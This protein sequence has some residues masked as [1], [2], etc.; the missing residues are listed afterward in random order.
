M[1]KCDCIL[2]D[3]GKLEEAQGIRNQYSTRLLSR[4]D[5]TC[6]PF[7][8][9]STFSLI[10]F[11]MRLGLFTCYSGNCSVSVLI[12]NVYKTRGY[13][14]KDDALYKPASIQ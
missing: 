2:F 5:R 9:G 4:D 6:L 10:S 11:N 7:S 8:V 3:S 1:S 13:Y 12:D 14:E